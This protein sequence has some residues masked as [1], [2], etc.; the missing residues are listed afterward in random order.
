MD[1][2]NCS[3][4]EWTHL[5]AQMLSRFGWT[6]LQGDPCL[7]GLNLSSAFFRRTAARC[8][9]ALRAGDI[10]RHLHSGPSGAHVQTV[11]KFHN[12]LRSTHH[13]DHS[14]MARGQLCG[15]IVCTLQGGYG[16]QA[17]N[18]S[19]RVEDFWET[20]TAFE[21]ILYDMDCW[22]F[23]WF[24]TCY[25]VWND[26]V[27]KHHPCSEIQGVIVHFLD[28]FQLTYRKRQDKKE[29]WKRQVS[30]SSIWLFRVQQ[31]EM[32]TVDSLGVQLATLGKHIMWFGHCS[33]EYESGMRLLLKHFWVC[34][35]SW[36]TTGRRLLLGTSLH[37][38]I[39]QRRAKGSLLEY[40]GMTQSFFSRFMLLD[41]SWYT[42]MPSR[43][44]QQIWTVAAGPNSSFAQ[45]IAWTDLQSDSAELR[46]PMPH[47]MTES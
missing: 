40:A 10:C 45:Q 24:C 21:A 6:L 47:W 23:K 34:S 37:V 12:L 31:Q 17:G 20:R 3:V 27:S 44:H 35:M 14:P 29:L 25:T 5:N 2:A 9:W 36:P 33:A 8:C 4:A 38:V 13:S 43:T 15:R 39:A 11:H 18:L 7:A 28:M 1:V 46:C 42:L 30:S 32:T 22:S 26:L 16:P 41:G 19:L